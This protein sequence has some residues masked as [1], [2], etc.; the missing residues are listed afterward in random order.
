MPVRSPWMARRTLL[1]ALSLLSCL[2]A[3][4]DTI[5]LIDGSSLKDVE[6]LAD[7]LDGVTYRR[8]GRSSEERLDAER[9]LSIER[10][11]LPS[12]VEQAERLVERGAIQEGIALLERFAANPAEAQRARQDWAVAHA[13]ERALRLQLAQSELAAAIETA[14][15]LQA[16]A[17][18][19]RH[20]PSALLAKAEAQR[21][22]GDTAG[23]QAT[24]D[25]LRD[26]IVSRHLAARWSLELDLA[27]LQGYLELPAPARRDRL[28]EIADQAGS[29]WPPVRNRARLLEA[30]SFLEG[31]APDCS[32][33]SELFERILAEPIADGDTLARAHAGLGDCQLHA[34]EQRLASGA[35]ATLDLRAAL[36]SFMR[37]VVLYPEQRELAAKCMFLA[38]HA[39]ELLGDEASKADARRLIA[40]LLQRHPGSKWAALAQ[41]SRK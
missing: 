17:P 34:A 23:A 38:A 19:S 39:C 40:A 1:V 18:Q 30:E 31:S 2:P 36:L 33:A 15:H 11:I 8:K 10:E 25:A 3:Q 4:A 9:V 24:L 29:S 13:L 21:A 7:Q 5:R 22:L 28:E 32:K 12:T 16:Q 27:R 37:V 20:V 6:V 35:D 14:N 26:L 41:E